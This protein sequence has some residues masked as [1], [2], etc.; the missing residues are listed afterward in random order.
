MC[1]GKPQNFSVVNR[2]ILKADMIQ[3]CQYILE[4]KDIVPKDIDFMSYLTKL[5]FTSKVNSESDQDNPNSPSEQVNELAIKVTREVNDCKM[6]YKVASTSK[7]PFTYSKL[8]TILVLFKNLG[9]PSYPDT[10]FEF[11]YAD[12]DQLPYENLSDE[13]A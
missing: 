3:F 5:G 2:P 1:N 9:E 13:L 11:G 4:A 8:A 12:M 7:I 10:L 6:Q